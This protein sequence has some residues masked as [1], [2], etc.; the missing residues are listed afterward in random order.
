MIRAA[1]LALRRKRVTPMNGVGA[2]WAANRVS[3]MPEHSP[4]RLT[5]GRTLTELARARAL[6]AGLRLQAGAAPSSS[7][8]ARI[9]TISAQPDL[10][11]S[12]TLALSHSRT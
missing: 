9:H 5:Q 6:A 1:V 12:G 11:H 2:E 7:S 8:T 10:W 3:P 4:Q